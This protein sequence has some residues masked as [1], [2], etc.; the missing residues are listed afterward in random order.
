MLKKIWLLERMSGRETLT[1][2]MM[3][4]TTRRSPGLIVRRIFPIFG[5]V[6][7]HRSDFEIETPPVCNRDQGEGAL[8]LGRTEVV[9]QP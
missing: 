7:R 4:R 6:V 9:E 5:V 3:K 8:A 2:T 1:L